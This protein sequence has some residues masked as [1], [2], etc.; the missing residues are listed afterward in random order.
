MKKSPLLKEL[1]TRL[2]KEI[3]FLDGAMGTMIQQ[4][5]LQEQDYRG[6]RYPNSNIDLKGNAETLN[7]TRPE[8]I[9]EIHTQ[10][11]AAG[12][13]IV[14]TNTFNAN[15]ISQK[16][17]ELEDESFAFNKK[18]AEI[19]IEAANA[20]MQANPNRKVYVAGSIGPTNRTAS[21]S[22]DVNRPG[23]RA[24]SF[25]DLVAA[26]REQ[27]EGLLA[28]GCELFL[29]ETAF[30]TLNLKACL[31]AIR[32]VENE[33]GV[34]YPVMISV[35]ITDASGRTLSG[36]TVEAF[37]NSVR[38]FEPMSVGLNCALGAREMRPFLAELSRVADCFISCYPNAG[39]P[40]PL[41]T[42]GYDE[43]PVMT[44][45]QLRSFSQEGLVNIVGGCCGT[46]PDHIREVIKTVRDGVPRAVPVAPPR[47]RLSGLESFN[48]ANAKETPF[49]MIGERTNVTGSPAFAKM[50]RENRMNDAVEVARQ[51]V[52]SGANILDVNFDE[53]MLDGAKYMTEFLNLLASEPDI[54]KIPFMIDSSKWEIIE[55]GLKC[56]QGKAIV[57][58]I[59]LKDGEEAFLQ[60]AALIR[61]YG[62]ATVVMAFDEQGQAA[63]KDDK[64]R[65][66]E[67]AYKLLREKLNFPAEDIIF[68]PNVLTV[69]TGMEEHNSYAADFIEAVKEIKVRCPGALTSGGISNLSFSFRGQNKVREAMHSVFLYHAVKNGLDMG[70]VNAGM[71]EVYDDIDPKLRRLVE[72]VIL[73]KSPEA[74]EELIKLAESMKNDKAGVKAVKTEEWRDGDLQARITHSLVHGIDA[75]IEKDVAEALKFYPI[76]LHIIEGPLMTGMKVVGE[77]FGEGKMFLPQVVKS[78]RVMKR[79]VAYLEPMM[80]ASKSTEKSQGVIVMATVKGD[81]HDIGKNIVG[82]VLACNGYRVVDLGVMVNVAQIMK[83]A[84]QENADMIGLSG[85]ITPSLDEMAFN[86]GEF[87]KAGLKI[88]VLIG[89]ATTSKVHTAVKLDQHYGFPVVHVPDASQ[90]IEHCQKLLLSS[91]RDKAYA[92]YKKESAEVRTAYELRRKNEEPP[93]SIE[94]AR[95]Y[96]FVTDWKT[97]EI[98]QPSRLGVFELYPKVEELTEYIDWSPFFWTWGLKGAYPTILDS[99]KYGEEATKLFKD[100]Q[101][102][103]K[104][105][106]E[107][108]WMKPRSLVGIYP[109][110]AKDDTIRVFQS[111][112]DL[113]EPLAEFP[114]LRQRSPQVFNGTNAF[115]LA[116]FIAPAESNRTDY[117]GMFAVTSGFEVEARANKFAEAKDDYSSILLK[118]LADRFAEANAEWTHKKVRD[119]FGYGLH[120]NLK[121]EELIQEKYRGI[122]PAPGYP[123]CPRHE[124]KRT[125]WKLMQVQERVGIELTES[126]AMYPGS[127][128][129]GFY[130]QHPAARYFTV[131]PQD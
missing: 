3:L 81:V 55:A 20:F 37:W 78:A 97:Q 68:D 92:D 124:D 112:D 35:T 117:L 6:D 61:Q 82:V 69:A 72:D 58:S 71:L 29:P 118:A 16:D 46:T 14:E 77:L 95:E 67:R 131:G 41:S 103:I 50:V 63:T 8:I 60:K 27:V 39:L 13:D 102:M 52:G 99:P 11:M 84:E 119:I 122:R 43:T 19:A 120:E 25:D 59:S 113:A 108:L 91:P 21:L 130:F 34:K 4:Y 106:R 45:S 93:M 75:H 32:Q 56:V 79:A 51:Q 87:Q 127:S 66:C 121:T 74:P 2:A 86:L 109:A 38:H 10:Y 15:R 64:V 23:Y 1:E 125:F 70:I 33:R 128:V 83:S 85:L 17:F 90:V 30:D 24:V 114:M 62:A 94:R 115:C 73:N 80:E 44:G 116:D 111:P 129:S 18:A 53:G 96:R 57:N 104:R 105:L 12:A 101:A 89:G 88:P 48:L 54:V 123:A 26:Y 40:N 5:K 22:P 107:G 9:K 100:A 47:M 65:I 110:N 31:F 126:M 76:P 49:V 42:T 36:Q 98:A 7:F 28:G